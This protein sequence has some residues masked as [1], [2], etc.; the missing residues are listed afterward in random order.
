MEFIKIKKRMLN[1]NILIRKLGQNE[2]TNEE[3]EEDEEEEMLNI[4]CHSSGR[5]VTEHEKVN[6]NECVACTQ[7]E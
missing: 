7:V 3:E 6:G 5:E 4:L 2:W 1:W